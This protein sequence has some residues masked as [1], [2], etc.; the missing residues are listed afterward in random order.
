MR[1]SMGDTTQPTWPTN[2]NRKAKPEKQTAAW[3]TQVAAKSSA[4]NRSSSN[5]PFST[6]P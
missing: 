4:P 1:D 5:Q 2:E 3:K 6:R